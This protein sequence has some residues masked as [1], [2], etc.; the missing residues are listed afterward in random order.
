LKDD[1]GK[2]II[3]TNLSASQQKQLAQFAK[4]DEGRAFLSQFAVKDKEYNIG[5]EK[6][7]FKVKE[8]SKHDVNYE[9]GDISNSGDTQTFVYK[10]GVGYV[11]VM[12]F[13]GDHEGARRAAKNKAGQF[14]SFR[15]TLDKDLSND[16]ALYTIGH[17]SFV[18]VDKN[19]KDLDKAFS[20]YNSGESQKNATSHNTA[21]NILSSAINSVA[22]GR[23]DHKLLV[24]GKVVKLDKFVKA[25]DEVLKT[26]KFTEQYNKDKDFY[27]KHPNY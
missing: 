12:D 20:D 16:R 8:S 10:P 21:E 1:N 25:L 4:T 2:D 23:G 27:K 15:V 3:I 14:Y 13:S 11:D 24:D 17:E 5:G 9:T 18:H 7:I 26:T 6:F 19:K 22:D